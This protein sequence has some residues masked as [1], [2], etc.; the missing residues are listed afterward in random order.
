MVV[1][2]WSP[3]LR[4]KGCLSHPGT[5]DVDILLS[6]AAA[7]FGIRKIID[8]FLSNG[9]LVSAKHDF[10]LLKSVEV[11][12]RNLVFNIDLLHPSET[13]RN[14][15]LFVD[16]FDL[17]IYENDL[18]EIKFVRSMVLPSSKILF[19]NEFNSQFKV[20]SP[21]TENSVNI[22][23]ITEAGC[24][25]SK[26]ESVSLAKRKRDAFDIYLSLTNIGQADFVKA[27]QPYADIDGVAA[28]LTSLR[29]FLCEPVENCGSTL[30]FD[31]RVLRYTKD[32]ILPCL[33]SAF[34][35][36]AINAVGYSSDRVSRSDPERLR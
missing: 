15:E 26:C 18:D 2:G 9:Y 13:Q 8:I 11:D 14:P 28:M 5:K 25:L 16:Q 31:S 1:G 4:Y 3:Y 23:L 32:A 10:Q 30:E 22:P 19:K 7:E 24:I 20:V 21:A 27:L 36:E 35:L 33:P 29:N 34:V 12:G 6:D 17:K